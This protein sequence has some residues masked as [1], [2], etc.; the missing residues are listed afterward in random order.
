MRDDP[1]VIPFLAIDEDTLREVAAMTGGEYRLAGSSDELIEVLARVPG[2]VTTTKVKR[3]VSAILVA[4]G[5]FFAL[6]SFSLAQLWHP[7]P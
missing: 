6:A 2:H 4:I 1:R 3:E 5:A 7:L